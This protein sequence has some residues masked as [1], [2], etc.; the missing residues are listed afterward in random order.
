AT[1][2]TGEAG[3]DGRCALRGKADPPGHATASSPGTRSR[4]GGRSRADGAHRPRQDG[5]LR[6][7]PSR[8]PSVNR[9]HLALFVVLCALWGFSFVTLKVA[10]RHVD[11]IFLASIRFWLPG[12]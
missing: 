5:R 3:G 11:P 7:R 2:A 8:A 6:S 12:F 10:L 4:G 9:K 1:E